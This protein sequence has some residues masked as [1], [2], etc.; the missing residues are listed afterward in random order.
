M[1]SYILPLIVISSPSLFPFV[2]L[3]SRRVIQWSRVIDICD[4][5]LIRPLHSLFPYL[6]LSNLDRFALILS[7]LCLISSSWYSSLFTSATPLNLTKSKLL[8]SLFFPR[9]YDDLLTSPRASLENLSQVNFSVGFQE[10][11]E[12]ECS[13]L[14]THL[15]FPLLHHSSSIFLSCFP[16][17]QS[18]RLFLTFTLKVFPSSS[19]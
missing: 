15:S 9:Y 7:L 17:L 4:T 10:V 2:V 13:Y 16:I 18:L 11:E 14:R 12:V 5:N 8:P 19:I 6:F 3:S 1:F